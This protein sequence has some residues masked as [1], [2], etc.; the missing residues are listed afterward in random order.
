MNVVIVY[1][2][3]SNDSLTREVCDS[4]IEGLE[5]AGHGYILLESIPFFFFY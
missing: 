1:C 4:F 5:S 2:H 3:P